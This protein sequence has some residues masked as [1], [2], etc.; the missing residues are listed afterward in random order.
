[1]PLG[2]IKQFLDGLAI[3]LQVALLSLTLGLFLGLLGAIAKLTEKKLLCTLV[4]GITNIIR[5]VPELLVLFFIYYGGTIFLS[6]LTGEYIEINAFVSGIVAL[7]LIF[8]AYATETLRGAFLAVPVGQ[9]EAAK[10]YGFSVWQTFTRIMLPQAWNHALPGLGNLWFV[11]LK[12][13]ALVALIGLADVMR[14]AQNVSATTRQPFTYY[15][16]AALI[17]LFLTT[18]SMLGQRYLQA[19]A[20]RYGEQI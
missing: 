14:V 7:G 16:V 15:S 13:T 8:G 11:L 19:R 10:A 12:D 4:N 1:M 18:L 17:Y 5:G 9:K 3:T 2:F 6:Q 20:N